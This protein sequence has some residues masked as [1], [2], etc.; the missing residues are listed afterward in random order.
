MIIYL[1]FAIS[2]FWNEI[3]WSYNNSRWIITTILI[4]TSNHSKFT[5][6]S[7]LFIWSVINNIWIKVYFSHQV[8]IHFPFVLNLIFN[9][10]IYIE[11]LTNECNIQLLYL[12]PI[13][14]LQ[15]FESFLWWGI[16]G[17]IHIFEYFN[18]FFF[19]FKFQSIF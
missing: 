17:S 1:E 2:I 7:N 10:Y 9:F 6:I 3:I 12:Y 16:N 19:F 11:F 14:N 13:F 4:D 18:T 15:V 8:I 5:H